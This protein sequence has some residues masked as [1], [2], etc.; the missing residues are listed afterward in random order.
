MPFGADA[1]AQQ[2]R[3]RDTLSDGARSPTD[4]KGRRNR[5]LLA[6]VIERTGLSPDVEVADA[7]VV[8]VCPQANADYRRA[9]HTTPLARRY[10]TLTT[11]HEV[12][13][14]TLRDPADLAVASSEALVAALR[15]SEHADSLTAWLAYHRDRY[16][17]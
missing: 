6:D 12:M 16:G 5:H 17:W 14:A 15:A 2:A 7:R 10:P 1:R 3:F 13:R 8:V 4:D 11:V 9:V